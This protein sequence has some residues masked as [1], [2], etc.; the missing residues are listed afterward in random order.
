MDIDL[1]NAYGSVPLKLIKSAMEPTVN[2]KMFIGFR[3][4][5]GCT[6]STLSMTTTP[7]PVC[8]CLGKVTKTV[9]RETREPQLDSSATNHMLYGLSYIDNNDQ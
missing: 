3:I 9:E 8:Y 4:S 5:E 7:D 1:V 6:I 2:Q